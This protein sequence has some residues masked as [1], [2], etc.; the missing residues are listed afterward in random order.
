MEN[1]FDPGILR[2]LRAEKRHRILLVNAPQGFPELFTGFQFDT[3]FRS[4]NRGKYDFVL[5]FGSMQTEMELLILQ[6]KDAGK[7]DALFWACYPK[8]GGKI[9]SDMKRDT[10]WA[11]LELVQLRPVTQISLDDTWTALRARPHTVI[12]SSKTGP[13]A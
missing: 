10:V 1:G 13:A 9:K 6:V 2:K 3:F 4:E 8:G 7:F 5:V 11:A 12:K